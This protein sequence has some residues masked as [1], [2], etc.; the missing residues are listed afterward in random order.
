MPRTPKAQ[1]LGR[2][3]RQARLRSGLNLREIGTALARD[4]G[5]LSRWETGERSPKPEHV[6]QYLTKL[7]VDGAQYEQIMTLAYGTNESL[8][9]AITLPEQKQQMA[10]YLDWEESATRIVEVAPLLVPG[11]VQTRKYINGIMTGGGVPPEV[12]SARIEERIERWKNLQDDVQVLVLLRQ[13]SLFQG[14]GG[15][16][17]IIEQIT[18][19]LQLIREP[20]FELRIIPDRVGWHPGLESAF[21]LIE[22]MRGGNRPESIVFLETRRSVLMLHDRADVESYREAIEQVIR[23]SLDWEA[24]GRL[25]QDMRTRLETSL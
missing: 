10:A 8:W 18:H 15:D 7:G 20:N 24:S 9:V 12:I 1:A 16:E 2:A 25:L 11:L 17:A 23:V 14:V 13:N 6:A 5:T 3:L 22:A 4:V 19:L 21:S